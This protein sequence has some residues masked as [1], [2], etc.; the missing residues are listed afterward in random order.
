MQSTMRPQTILPIR[1]R[2][3]TVIPYTAPSPYRRFCVF[4]CRNQPTR[5]SWAIPRLAS[6][7]QCP[8]HCHRIGRA[9]KQISVGFQNLLRYCRLQRGRFETP[10]Q[11]RQPLTRC[12]LENLELQLRML[13][14]RHLQLNV[15]SCGR[16][17]GG[18]VISVQQAVVNDPR[19]KCNRV[20]PRARASGR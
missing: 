8:I 16:S 15:H 10:S 11:L 7:I 2:L 6:E 12:T 14:A 9:D 4:P 5:L 20:R 19:D 18:R 17:S 13:P 1:A 3:E